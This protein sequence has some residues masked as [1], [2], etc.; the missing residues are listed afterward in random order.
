MVRTGEKTC[1]LSNNDSSFSSSQG[2]T[3]VCIMYVLT[4]NYFKYLFAVIH[5]IP[6]T[7][8]NCWS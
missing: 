6:K 1:F 8:N 4:P 2:K 5:V 3:T 7:K